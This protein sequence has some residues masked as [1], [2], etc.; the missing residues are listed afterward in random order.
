M[1]DEI[2][3]V[4]AELRLRVLACREKIERQRCSY[5]ELLSLAAFELAAKEQLYAKLDELLESAFDEGLKTG[6]ENAVEQLRALSERQ[7]IE[8]L[9]DGVA[10]Q[11]ARSH[12]VGA[13]VLHNR[14]GGSRE[15]A[16]LVLEMWQSGKYGSKDECAEAAERL[17]GV[18]FQTARNNLKGK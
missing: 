11:K 1:S 17:H 6:F 13:D 10:F 5:E 2:D 8:A 9:D 7:V 16:R 3:P 4:Q 18:V 15:K 12:R 14:P